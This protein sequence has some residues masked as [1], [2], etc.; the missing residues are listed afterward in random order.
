MVMF[1]GKVHYVRYV[2]GHGQAVVIRH[3][4]GLKTIYLHPS[5][6]L[7]KPNQVVKKG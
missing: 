4:N 1:D 3:E 5:R 2:L 7:V 6:S